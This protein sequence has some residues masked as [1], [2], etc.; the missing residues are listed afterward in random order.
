[1]FARSS[2]VVVLLLAAA[3]A[4]TETEAPAPVVPAA[5][6]S[7]VAPRTSAP[8][9]C[10]YQ[11]GTSGPLSNTMYIGR[12]LHASCRY[13]GI[14][15][16]LR[17]RI[18]Y[19]CRAPFRN[20]RDTLRTEEDLDEVHD[21]LVPAAK[22]KLAEALAATVETIVDPAC[23]WKPTDPASANPR[24]SECP[25]PDELRRELTPAS[26]E[27]IPAGVLAFVS[28]WAAVDRELFARLHQRALLTC[29]W[30]AEVEYTADHECLVDGKKEERP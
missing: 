23:V 22:D 29:D 28:A 15:E 17:S 7:S 6:V 9:Y 2:I 10:T 16:G 14:V 5:S 24:V 26:L 8:L 27:S 11:E 20:L 18:A 30:D 1:M 3:C 19:S 25:L 21:C 4:Q 12:V 13:G